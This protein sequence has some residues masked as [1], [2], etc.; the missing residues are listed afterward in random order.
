MDV[1]ESQY[2]LDLWSKNICP[3]C[4]KGIPE[5]KRVGSGRKNE[6]GFCSLACYGNYYSLELQE[7]ARK[8]AETAKR[9]GHS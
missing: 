4:G 2:L 1:P 6:G 8:V 3:W 9:H 7:R 5:G